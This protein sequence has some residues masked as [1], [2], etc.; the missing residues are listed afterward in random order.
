TLLERRGLLP[1]QESVHYLLQ[2]ATGVAHAAARGVVHRDIKPSN[3]IVTPSGRA[4]LVDMGLA[5]SLEPHDNRQLTQAADPPGLVQHL[6]QVAQQ[7]GGVE[8]GEGVLFVDAPLP[9]GPRK[10]PVL[11]G[12][13]AAAVLGAFV[14]AV[15]LVPP[16]STSVALPKA[17]TAINQNKGDDSA[18]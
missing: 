17:K 9:S 14:L 6:L 15:A 12:A 4:K 8:A 3:I 13:I 11:L 18:G 2:I 7:L 16:R 5:R 1:V 10:R